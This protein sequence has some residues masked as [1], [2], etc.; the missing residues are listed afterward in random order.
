MPELRIDIVCAVPQT[1]PSVLASSILGRAQS[2]GLVEIHVHNLH[3]YA[4]DKYKHIDDKPYGGGAGM[5]IT[6]Q[7]IMDCIDGLMKDRTYDDV[8]YLC[9][10]GERLTQATCNA[11]SIK[12]NIIMIAGHY[13]GID[14]RVRDLVVTREISVGDYVLTG[15][16][17]AAA[18]LTDA[19]VRLVPGVISD[20]E[21]ALEDSFMHG[22]LEPPLYTKPAEYRGLHVPEILFSGNHAAIAKWRAEQALQRTRERRPD[23]LDDDGAPA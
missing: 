8:I 9:P 17:L 21:S 7:P 12:Q 20:A 19:I 11:L 6:C 10:D 15:G 5:V 2:K 18:V 14:Q 4:L 23:L 1:L 13:K 3:D 22:L 16:E